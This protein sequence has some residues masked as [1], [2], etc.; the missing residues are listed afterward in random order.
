MLAST[1]P[2]LHIPVGLASTATSG[3]VARH[4]H[5]HHHHQLDQQVAVAWHQPHQHQQQGEQVGVRAALGVYQPAGPARLLGGLFPCLLPYLT[6]PTHLP[7]PP[8]LS[9]L[10][11]ACFRP[12]DISTGALA[13]GS[14]P[15]AHFT[16][17]D[18]WVGGSRCPGSGAGQAG[19]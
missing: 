9:Q 5:H 13:M 4:Q 6:H 10:Q 12:N 16:Q 19:M 3:A 2:V 11:A 18:G 7:T 15:T 8:I 17:V 1:A 14:S